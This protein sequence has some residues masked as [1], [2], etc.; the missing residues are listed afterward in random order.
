MKNFKIEQIISDIRNDM[1]DIKAHPSF[2]NNF[3]SILNKYPF[4]KTKVLLGNLVSTLT[5]LT[6]SETLS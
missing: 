4:K 2:E 5:S 1:Y 6:N 3:I